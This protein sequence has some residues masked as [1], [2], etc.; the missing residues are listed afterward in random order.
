MKKIIDFLEQSGIEYSREMYGNPYYYNDGFSVPALIVKFD[1]ELTEDRRTLQEK[2]RRFIQY[3]DR[4][5]AYCLPFSGRCG[6]CIPWYTVMGVFDCKRYQEH[7]A[8]IRAD[9]E[10]FWQEEHRRREAEKLAAA[11]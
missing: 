4:K 1:Y 8:R 3:M 10:K 2:E 5:R 11:I 7:Q 9:S 6:V